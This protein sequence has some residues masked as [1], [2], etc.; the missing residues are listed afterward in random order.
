M[1]LEERLLASFP[2]ERQFPQKFKQSALPKTFSP[3][4]GEGYSAMTAVALLFDSRTALIAPQRDH[5]IFV[6]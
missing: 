1:V 3:G 5:D 6:H 4:V 2:P